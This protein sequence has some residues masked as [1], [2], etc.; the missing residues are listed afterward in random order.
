MEVRMS[1]KIKI[2]EW[3]E[4]KPNI[5]IKHARPDDKFADFIDLLN[6]EQINQIIGVNGDEKIRAYKK[7]SKL[8]DENFQYYRKHFL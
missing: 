5:E 6:R 1:L 2:L 3:L 7:I 4:I 8:T